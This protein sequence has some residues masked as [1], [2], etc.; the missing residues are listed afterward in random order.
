MKIPRRRKKTLQ[1]ELK[2]LQLL[3]RRIARLKKSQKEPN[4]DFPVKNTKTKRYNNIEC[5]KYASVDAM[6]FD[7]KKTT[8]DPKKRYIHTETTYMNTLCVRIILIL[9]HC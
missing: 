5:T 6:S 9:I 8:Q 1:S 2:K 3:D 4:M 7:P